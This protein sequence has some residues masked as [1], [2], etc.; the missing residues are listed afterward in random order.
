[1]CVWTFDPGGENTFDRNTADFSWIKINK[2][3]F[4]EINIFLKLKEENAKN[5]DVCCL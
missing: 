1:M 5:V 2:D 4:K 3:I